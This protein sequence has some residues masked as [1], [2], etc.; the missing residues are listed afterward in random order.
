MKKSLLLS[1]CYCFNIYAADIKEVSQ[2]AA[3]ISKLNNELI[4]VADNNDV[5]RM[6]QLLKAGAQVQ[7]IN[8]EDL[9]PLHVAAKR[10]NKEAVM[11]LLQA[12]AQVNAKNQDGMTPLHEAAAGN[13]DENA[14]AYVIPTLVE[15]GANTAAQD[16][17]YRT[18]FNIAVKSNYV[19]G[20]RALVVSVSPSEV[21]VGLPK[22]IQKKL[23]LARKYL[24]LQ[25]E[26]LPKEEAQ[27]K[28]DIEASFN[29]VKN[30]NH[31]R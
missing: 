13:N 6:S 24:P 16:N 14:G 17:L 15:A 11:Q 2:Q 18:P 21:N 5:I 3:T 27:L 29:R 31:A 7:F 25:Q 9:T 22:I 26:E 20:I 23:E 1:L 10:G 4:D 12:K 8:H 30:R 19:D 28:K